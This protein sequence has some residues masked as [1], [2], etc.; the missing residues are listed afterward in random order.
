MIFVAPLFSRSEPSQPAGFVFSQRLN[1]STT[2]PLSN[3]LR[4][5]SQKI[6]LA[7][8]HYKKRERVISK[9]ER[10]IDRHLNYAKHE[11]LRKLERHLN[12][13]RGLIRNAVRLLKNAGVAADLIFDL[14][15]FAEG[16]FAALRNESADALQTAGDELYQEIQSDDVWSMPDPLAKRFLDARR[17]LLRDVPDEVFKQVENAI[18]EGLDSGDSIRGMSNR[19]SKVFNDISQG[20]AVTIASTETGAAYGFARQEAMKKASVQ[21]KSWLTS[22]LPNVRHAHWVAERNPANQRVPL[23][24]P[25]IVGGEELMHP[26]DSNG[27]PENVINCHCIALA[28]A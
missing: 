7:R 21:F 23:E 13:R 15:Q 2:Q 18:Q 1:F 3:A 25:F 28:V 10:A 6:D 20:R 14:D 8:S 17:N 5:I 11:T 27:S 16:L 9:F 12:A 24:D 26:G 19:I 22:H 4:S